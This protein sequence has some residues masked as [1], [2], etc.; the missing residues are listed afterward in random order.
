WNLRLIGAQERVEPY[1]KSKSSV[2]PSDQP[3]LT[4]AASALLSRV[5]SETGISGSLIDMSDEDRLIIVEAVCRFIH[6]SPEVVQAGEHPMDLDENRV[7]RYAG[8]EQYWS[9]DAIDDLS[10]PL[11]GLPDEREAAM[12]LTP[13]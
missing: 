5:R 6:S 3:V 7:S 8:Q 4:A 1:E 13:P 12:F 11:V 9:V 2:Q 10:P